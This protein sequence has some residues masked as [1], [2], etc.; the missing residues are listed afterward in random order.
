MS[1]IW[2]KCRVILLCNKIWGE[3]A[4]QSVEEFKSEIGCAVQTVMEH[5]SREREQEIM[6]EM[7]SVKHENERVVRLKNGQS[8]RAK[9]V[10]REKEIATNMAREI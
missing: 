9:L 2:G 8:L 7:I 5:E 10:K 3:C 4:V 1:E 6:F